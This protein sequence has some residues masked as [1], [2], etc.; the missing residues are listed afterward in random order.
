MSEGGLHPPRGPGAEPGA[1]A[2]AQGGAAPGGA[3]QIRRAAPGDAAAICAI[4]NPIIRDTVITF[5]SVEKTVEEVAAQ[6]REGRPYW[7]AGAPGAVIGYASYGAF[8]HG[9]GYRHT[10]EHSIA[11]APEAWG[12][13]IGRALMEAL[14][15]AARAEGVHVLIAGV[16][17]ENPA[18]QR[19][20]AALGFAEIARLPQVGRKFGRWQDL[21]LMQKFL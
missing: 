16:G 5:N 4:A 8:R 19:F 9:S 3:V 11:L 18:G 21:V 20:H 1:G 15:A 14:C 10:R 6:I 13:G 7:V 17:G 2:E 12:R